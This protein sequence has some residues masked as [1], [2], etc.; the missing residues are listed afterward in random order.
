MDYADENVEEEKDERKREEGSKGDGR[1]RERE[2]KTEKTRQRINRAR[3]KDM[4]K[5]VLTSTTKV[6]GIHLID[7]EP[8]LVALTWQAVAESIVN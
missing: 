6:T 2:E 7:G 3:S 8:V 5:R 4:T 1:G